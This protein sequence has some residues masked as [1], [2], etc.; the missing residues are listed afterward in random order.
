MHNLIRTAVVIMVFLSFCLSQSTSY[1]LRVKSY[2]GTGCDE[3]IDSDYTESSIE[4]E[5]Q[6]S[7]CE[8][9]PPDNLPIPTNLNLPSNANYGEQVTISWDHVWEGCGGYSLQ[10]REAGTNN[11]VGISVNSG[12]Q[13][14]F[15]IPR[16]VTDNH[17]SYAIRVSS[18]WGIG[19]D[20]R[21]FS[22]PIE[23]N[24]EI[25]CAGDGCNGEQPESVP[26]PTYLS[27]DNYAYFGTPFTVSW[28]HIWEGCGG[29][30][31]EYR[32]AGTEDWHPINVTSGSEIS[33][34]ISESGQV[35]TIKEN[36]G[37]I[38][39]S[40]H[41]S[42][43]FPNPFNPTTTIGYTLERTGDV[44]IR[45]LNIEG[46]IVETLVDN[47]KTPGSY[48]VYWNP[49]AL[50]SGQYFYQIVVDGQ[51]VSTKKAVFLK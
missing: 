33:L 8:G 19:C 49:S 17:S 24:I 4:L 12:S 22:D 26:N 35:L 47:Y 39:N 36:G 21:S 29:Y 7:G 42:Q 5:C 51:P 25:E 40:H 41:L 46:Q 32:R 38:P 28:D 43:N 6:G 11:W 37:S 14:T 10:Y 9:D 1:A 44:K 3:Q 34:V 31:F 18:Y 23:G 15:A 45:I 27:H 2:W 16:L 30:A 50:S 13:V 20:Q 48:S